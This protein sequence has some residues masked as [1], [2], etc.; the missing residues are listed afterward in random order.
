MT[1]QTRKKSPEPDAEAVQS[2]GAIPDPRSGYPKPL[3]QPLHPE[4]TEELIEQLV[5]SFYTKVR[6]DSDLGPVFAREI[7]ED[8]EPH[9][10]KMFD[11]WSSV[12]RMTGRYRGKPTAV[13]HRLTGV[14]PEHFLRWLTLFRETAR[15]LCAPEVAAI[16]IDRAERIGESLQLAMFFDPANPGRILPLRETP[17]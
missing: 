9:L 10:S 1:D 13:H 15:T 17:A 14:E 11:F 6:A 8:W 7:G 16:F 4:I 12:T 3:R 2:L 5:R